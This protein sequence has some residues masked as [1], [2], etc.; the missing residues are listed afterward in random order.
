M[1]NC[2]LGSDFF[3]HCGCQIHYDTGTFIVGDIEVT[4]LKM[5]AYDFYSRVE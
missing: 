5:R 1:Y 3:Q 2:I 4:P